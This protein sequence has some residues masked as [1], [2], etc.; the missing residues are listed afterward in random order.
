MAI[1]HGNVGWRVSL[2]SQFVYRNF[3]V[4]VDLQSLL[5]NALSLGRACEE[6]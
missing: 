6:S 4:G 3:I 5:H 2:S 1:H